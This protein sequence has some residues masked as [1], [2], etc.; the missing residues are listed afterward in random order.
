MILYISSIPAVNLAQ[1]ARQA[2]IIKLIKHVVFLLQLFKSV[3]SHAWECI[4]PSYLFLYLVDIKF[5]LRHQSKFVLM[6]RDFIK[7][8]DNGGLSLVLLILFVLIAQ[9]DS[10]FTLITGTDWGV[11]WHPSLAYVCLQF[12]GLLR[13]GALVNK[14]NW[15]MANLIYSKLNLSVH[16]DWS[17]VLPQVVILN[18]CKHGD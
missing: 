10:V 15:L 18:I 8:L 2:L 5:D 11:F 16:L 6:L 12:F 17:L 3:Y 4:F 14:E 7:H 13:L 9:S 1:K